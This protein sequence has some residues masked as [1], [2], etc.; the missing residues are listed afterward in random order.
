MEII[1]NSGLTSFP[2]SLQIAVGAG[3]TCSKNSSFFSFQSA[4]QAYM[5]KEIQQNTNHA[6]VLA[7]VVKLY[8]FRIYHVCKSLLVIWRNEG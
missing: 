4:R 5:K 2:I 7:C 1:F 6:V 3:S 8:A